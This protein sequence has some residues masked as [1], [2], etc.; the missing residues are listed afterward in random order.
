MLLTFVFSDRAYRIGQKRNVR[1]VRL[2]SKGTV[3]EM[4]YLRQIYKEHLKQDTL[5]EDDNGEAPRVFRGVQ[6]DKYRKGELFGTENLFR[7][8]EHGSFLQDIYNVGST[9]R[10]RGKNDSSGF[11][12]HDSGKV[13][14]VL[15][16]MTDEQRERVGNDDD[17]VDVNSLPEDP[18]PNVQGEPVPAVRPQEPEPAPDFALNHKDLFRSDRGGAAI[19]PGED[20]FDEEM[21]GQ[22]QAAYDVFENVKDDL[23]EEEE[24]DDDEDDEEDVGNENDTS[25]GNYGD[26]A[27]KVKQETPG[28]TIKTEPT[29]MKFEQTNREMNIKTEPAP[30]PVVSG[31]QTIAPDPVVSSRQTVLP[32]PVASSRQTVAP[33]PVS[34][35]RQSI[36]PM[37]SERTNLAEDIL[38]DAI[39]STG[40]SSSLS[41]QQSISN[42]AETASPEQKLPPNPA[43]PA[44]ENHSRSESPIES[45]A[46][47]IPRKATTTKRKV[48]LMGC[49]NIGDTKTKFSAA[50]LRRPE[51]GKKKK[52]K[53]KKKSQ[54]ESG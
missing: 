31:G 46:N 7:F 19:K 22:T 12:I 40:M 5:E 15:L 50:D 43:P 34:S 51:Y 35:S 39:P 27:S 49:N 36:S 9:P 42:Q 48:L 16:G 3:E 28:N 47:S 17:L 6:G 4:I 21:G 24:E 38:P 41:H 20:G 2:I 10:N 11:E 52:K 13:S 53:K 23:S 18:I 29:N 54:G 44:N 37:T 32:D 26:L 14:E 30:D 1:V 25:E 45:R 8:K 33:D